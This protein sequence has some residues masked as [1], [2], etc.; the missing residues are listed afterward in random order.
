MIKKYKI[1]EGNSNDLE[2]ICNLNYAIFKGLYSEE[3]YNLEKYQKRLNKKKPLIY[4][5]KQ[6][7]ILLGNSIAFTEKENLYLWI[8]GVSKK[9][10]G[11]GLAS[12]LL[13]L[14][15]KF[16]KKNEC[17]AVTVKVYNSSKEMMRLLLKRGYNIMEIKDKNSNPN[18]NS[19]Y[20]SYNL[21]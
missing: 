17:E 10:R 14:N 11:N 18:F 15:E 9:H 19:A 13:D 20:F 1:A 3:P 8:L 2:A 5:I 16:A 21:K 4:I 7:E 6:G 12:K